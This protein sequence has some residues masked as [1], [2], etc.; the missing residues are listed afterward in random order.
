MNDPANTRVI[1]VMRHPGN[2]AVLEQAVAEVEMTGVSVA[3]ENGLRAEL[4]RDT[5]ARSALVDV[6]GFG[7]Q[8]WQLC[9]I[10]QQHEI[11]FVVLS[12]ANER[13]VGD[14]SLAYGATSVLQKPVAKSA[15]LQLV[16]NLD[17]R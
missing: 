3:D 9:E 4:A 10:L 17:G 6:S 11:P 16:R 2:A 14:R 13:D 1:L 8:V 5:P 12:T 7:R 15:L